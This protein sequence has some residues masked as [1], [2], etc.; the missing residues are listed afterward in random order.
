SGGAKNGVGNYFQLSGFSPFIIQSPPSPITIVA[1]DTLVLRVIAGG[2]AP[3]SYQWELNSNNVVNGK[4]VSGAT[5]PNLTIGNITTMQAGVYFVT[6][7]NSAGQI[8]SASARVS[9]IPRPK[10]TIT[11]PER[12]AHINSSSQTITGTT[13][14]E[15]AVARVYFQLDDG[16]WRL[17]T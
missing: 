6:V 16:G 10:I 5:S 11:S 8:A 9:V 7:Q 4:F 13:G 3:L 17:A 12:G 2:T 14:G 15:V 1:G